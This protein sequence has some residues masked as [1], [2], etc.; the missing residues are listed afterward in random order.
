[1]IRK[2]NGYSQEVIDTLTKYKN[3]AEDGLL[4]DWNI[5]DLQTGYLIGIIDTIKPE[6]VVE[7]GTL[8]C[9]FDYLFFLLNK[10]GYLYTFDINDCSKPVEYL[11]GVVGNRITFYQGDSIAT[12]RKFNP[13]KKIDMAWID[14]NHGY[15]HAHSDLINCERL[16]I[17]NILVDDYVFDEVSCAVNTFLKYYDYDLI[18]KSND[19]RQIAYI[20]RR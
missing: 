10:N 8:C 7:I 6:V 19:S 13:N 11:N 16:E 17:P 5:G 15:E 2:L 3:T 18:T 20:K 1:M 14:G 9:Y 4:T 12:F